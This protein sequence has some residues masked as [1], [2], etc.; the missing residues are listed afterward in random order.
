MA[1]VL[2]DIDGT[3]IS[4]GGAG[5][6]AFAETFRELF[7]VDQI[8]S[9]VG[10]AGRSDKAIAEDLMRAHD[11]E[12][13]SANWRRF[14]TAFVPRLEQ[15]LP[16]SDGAILPGISKLLD[17]LE[18][19]EHVA[20]GLLTGNIAAGAK[21]KLSHYQLYERFAFGGYGDDWTDRC[22]I[23][24]A[25]LEAARLH[26]N[27]TWSATEKVIVIGDTPADIKCARAIEAFAVGV[28][29]GGAS[30]EE[31]ADARPDLLVSD[32]TDSR[33]LLSQLHAISEK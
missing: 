30:I 2:F 14:T 17:E 7:G 33:D 6:I 3:L 16:R 1:T 5:R 20:I 19:M 10:F 26:R 15:V 28:A 9:T 27:G 24:V 31:L 18:A 22:D 21:A 13:T 23:A 8:S 4:T 32:L 29:T 12:V 25:A 11:I